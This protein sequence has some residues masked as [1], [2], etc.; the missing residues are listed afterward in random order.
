MRG[1]VIL[2]AA[3]MIVKL[4][5]AVYRIPFQNIVGDI[6]FYIYQQVYPFYGIF[7]VLATTG[8]PVV[9]SKLYIEQRT[10]S[11]EEGGRRLLKVA[12]LLLSMIAV[13]CCFAMYFSADALAHYMNDPQLADSLRI[14]AISFLILPL[15]SV[16]RGFFKE[17]EI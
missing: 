3:G 17:K 16:L 10:K 7:L 5:S 8:F 13:L 9:I 12:G 1:A 11:G 6:G 4:L 2:T 14:V 15:V